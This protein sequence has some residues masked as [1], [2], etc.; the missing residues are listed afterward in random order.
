MAKLASLVAKIV[1]ETGDGVIEISTA[2]DDGHH[3]IV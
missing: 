3:D 1:V 2:N